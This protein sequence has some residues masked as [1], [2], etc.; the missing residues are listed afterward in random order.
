MMNRAQQFFGEVRQMVK[1]LEQ[2]IS[3]RRTEKPTTRP[4]TSAAA[5]QVNAT[6]ARPVVPLETRSSSAP[7]S[8]SGSE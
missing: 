7:R 4:L 8:S 2:Q 3:K 6:E 1:R 5:D